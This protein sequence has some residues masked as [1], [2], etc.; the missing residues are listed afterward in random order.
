MARPGC[1]PAG[2]HVPGTGRNLSACAARSRSPLPLTAAYELSLAKLFIDQAL[3]SAGIGSTIV[4]AKALERRAVPRAVVAASMV[5]NIASYHAAY[6]VCLGVAL[7]ITTSRGETHL[8]V[9]LV[10]VLF[11][12]FSVAVTAG[13]LLLSG[14]D[15]DRVTVKLQRFAALRNALRFLKDADPHLTR[16]SPLL[17]EAT[18]WQTAIFLLDAASMWV[19]IQ[20]LGTTSSPGAV[21]ASFMIASVFRTVGIVPGGLGVFEATSVWTLNIIGVSVPIGLA[22]TLLF[23]GLS[24]WL[25][26]LPGW[27]VSGRLAAGAVAAPPPGGH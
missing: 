23:R 21:F 1:V 9:L 12:A 15:V 25:P 10:S 3:P 16:H 13:L 27:W 6:V 11:V 20:S 5:V 19:L 18:G 8:P 24:F 26:M 17:A 22:A 14:R 4:V 7:A 2:R